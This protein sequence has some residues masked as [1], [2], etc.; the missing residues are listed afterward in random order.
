MVFV[1]AMSCGAPVIGAQSGGP[2]DFVSSEV[3]E[4]VPEAD[5]TDEL[6]VSLVDAVLRSI[7]E[8]WRTT[9]EEA[10]ITLVDTKYSAKGQCT[11]LLANAKR[12]L[13]QE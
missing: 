7:K 2:L 9:K 6:S 4:L 11:D 8:D 13:K 10:C 12:M 5:S 1:E 3:G